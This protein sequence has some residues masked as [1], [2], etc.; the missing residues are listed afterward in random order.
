MEQFENRKG[1]KMTDFPV[2][3]ESGT[4]NFR[5]RG[6]GRLF[7]I[8]EQKSGKSSPLHL[9]IPPIKTNDL[10]DSVSHNPTLHSRGNPT[11]TQM[12]TTWMNSF[13]QQKL[14]RLVGHMMG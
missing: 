14:S 8:G 10:V 12:F 7:H 2:F 9:A 13:T 11:Q 3:W 6:A 1:W 5:K 4:L